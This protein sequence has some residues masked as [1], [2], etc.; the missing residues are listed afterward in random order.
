MV[1][2]IFDERQQMTNRIS[3]EE[4]SVIDSKQSLELRIDRFNKQRT[5]AASRGSAPKPGS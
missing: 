4:N 2:F 1:D 5:N 3:T